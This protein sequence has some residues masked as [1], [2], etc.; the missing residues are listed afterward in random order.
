MLHRLVRAAPPAASLGGVSA[1][2]L[3]V[4]P[5]RIL[6]MVPTAGLQTLDPIHATACVGRSH[7]HMITIG[8]A[9]ATGSGARSRGGSP[10]GPSR[11]TR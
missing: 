7:A 4:P 10:P 1:A 9:P 6:R 2:A 3:P 11:T 5:E 8:S